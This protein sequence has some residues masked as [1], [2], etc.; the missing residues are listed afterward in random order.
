MPGEFKFRPVFRQFTGTALR[1]RETE[2]CG[3]VDNARPYGDGT[4]SR[5]FEKEHPA[6]ITVSGMFIV[7]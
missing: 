7:S 3:S 2:T 5:W 6:G 1:E 4:E